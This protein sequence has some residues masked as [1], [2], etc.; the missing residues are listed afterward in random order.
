MTSKKEYFEIKIEE[1]QSL[2]EWAAD[3]AERALDI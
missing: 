3:C 2:G 1:L